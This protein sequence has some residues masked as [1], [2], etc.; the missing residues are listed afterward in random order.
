MRWSS[1]GGN[2]PLSCRNPTERSSKTVEADTD[3]EDSEMGE[4]VSRILEM[5]PQLTRTQLLDV[6]S[7]FSSLIFTSFL[8]QHDIFFTIFR[9]L[10]AQLR[11]KVLWQRAF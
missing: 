3:D 11:W 7:L 6:S 4:K 5:F 8:E 10:G 2:H 1:L 9:S